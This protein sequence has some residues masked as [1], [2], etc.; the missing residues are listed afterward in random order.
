MK[1]L[2]AFIVAQIALLL[3]W[4]GSPMPAY[5]EVLIQDYVQAPQTMLVVMFRSQ[6]DK[7]KIEWRLSAEDGPKACELKAAEVRKTGATALCAQVH[8][9]K[10]I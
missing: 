7:A 8:D 5:S 2:R 9:I 4:C 6:T 1:R 10:K 3:S